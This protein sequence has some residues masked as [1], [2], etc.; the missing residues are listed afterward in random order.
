MIEQDMYKKGSEKIL[1]TLKTKRG[2]AKNFATLNEGMYL[3]TREAFDL[4]ELLKSNTVKKKPTWHKV[5]NLE[6]IASALLL[7]ASKLTIESDV[8]WKRH[9]LIE[10]VA[11]EFLD[12]DMK[13]S[14]GF[15]EWIIENSSIFDKTVESKNRKTMVNYILKPEVSE[16]II[17][18]INARAAQE[19]YP[20]PITEAPEDWGYSDTVVYGGYKTKQFPIVR[21]INT[22][23]NP[24]ILNNHLLK[25]LNSMQSVPYRI[26]TTAL[27]A[28]K[29]DLVEPKKSDYVKISFPKKSDNEWTPEEIEAIKLYK[30]QIKQYKSEVGKYRATKLM[31]DIAD[32]Y[33]NEERIY[34]PWNFD[35]RGRM[36]PIAVFLNPQGDD[37][38][39]GILEFADGITL[40]K[41]GERA[42]YYTL[43][44]LFG[45]DKES[46]ENRIKIGKEVVNTNYLE[47]DEPYQFLALQTQVQKWEADNSILIYTP[48]HLDGCANG[49]QH[50]AMLT[51]CKSTAYATNILPSPDGKRR[52]LYIEVANKSI[53]LVKTSENTHEVIAYILECLESNGRKYAKNPTM[54]K[55]YGGKLQTFADSCL[56]NMNELNYIIDMVNQKTSFAFAKVISDALNII[57]KGGMV[58]EKWIQASSRVL[59]NENKGFRYTT[60]D[61]FVV[62]IDRK[63]RRSEVIRVKLNNRLIKLSI[64]KNTPDIDSLKIKS[65]ISPNVIHSLDATHLR[66]TLSKCI[67]VGMTQFNFI[68][69]SFGCD[70]NNMNFLMNATKE[71]WIELYGN[72][73]VAENLANQFRCQTDKEII[74]CSFLGGF[75]V[76]EVMKSEYFFS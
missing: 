52:D 33:K 45:A 13:L 65:G 59:T 22:K 2:K 19:F 32:Q 61:G 10:K 28:V 14:L 70:M 31:L 25:C 71:A 40:N 18:Q 36:Y 24:I 53:E 63:K 5:A 44:G 23:K 64:N 46:A 48:C 27:E 1:G 6:I 30:L 20:L 50:A 72:F 42:M 7:I 66:M 51:G 47:A 39:K 21:G 26:N 4:H 8:K 38:T 37:K 73:D 17:S 69:D 35:Y 58:F 41:A 55:I 11:N 29:S 57:L 49:S 60:P 67:D 56:K 68:H 54:V 34:F 3:I 43:A 16:K 62:S 74:S 12:S 9:L 76:N 15:T 75:D